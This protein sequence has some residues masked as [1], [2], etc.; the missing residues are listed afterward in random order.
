[1]KIMTMTIKRNDHDR[2]NNF[3]RDLDP[4]VNL[5]RICNH[6]FDHDFESCWRS[7]HQSRFP[8]LRPRIESACGLRFVDLNLTPRIFLR[9]LRFSSLCKFDFHAMIWA[10]ERLNIS[11][12]LG[13][14]G[15][16]F[17]AIDV[18]IKYLF[19]IYL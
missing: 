12:W 11:L 19:I 8:P 15:N 3:N 13:R 7:G 14:T 5:D 6:D 1:M 2:N 17:L 4:N 9:V 16:H 18:K 10:V